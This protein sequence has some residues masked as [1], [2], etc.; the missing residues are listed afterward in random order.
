MCGSEQPDTLARTRRTRSGMRWEDSYTGQLRSLVGNR[1]LIIPGPRA[2]VRN[3]D[4]SILFVKRSDN[5][6]WVMPAGQIEIGESIW[7]ALVREVYEETGL[8]VEE[9]MPIAIYSEDR[10]SFTNAYGAEHQMFAVAF[11]VTQWRGELR[12]MTDETVDA[13]FFP[14][15]S[16]PETSDLYLETLSDL[17][18]FDGQIILK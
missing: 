8:N 2:I 5:K 13:R 7:E 14:R 1:K 4:G 9:A 3:Q 10:F 15:D 12:R 18:A 17:D 11:L 16:L 6:N